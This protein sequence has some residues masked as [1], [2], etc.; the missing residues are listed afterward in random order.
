MSYNETVLRILRMVEHGA[1]TP[2][3]AAD[4]IDALYEVPPVS[5]TQPD[6]EVS[7]PQP[8]SESARGLFDQIVRTVEEAVRTTGQAVRGV[9]WRELGETI[10]SQTQRG[11]EEM[12]RALDE[13][14][15]GDWTLG[16]LGKQSHTFERQIPLPIQA[17]QTLTLELPA[18]DIYLTGGFDEG[19][20]GARISLRGADEAQLSALEQ[21][22]T[23]MVEH[24]E[25]GLKLR[26]PELENGITQEADLRLMV[27]RN[28]NVEV[29]L[30]GK[31]DVRIDKLDGKV[32]IVAQR[33]DIRLN[34]LRGSVTVQLANGDVSVLDMQGDTLS[35]N[36][37]HGDVQMRRVKVD[38]LQASLTHG[39][40]EAEA[41]EARHL[42]TETVNGDQQVQ[43]TQPVQGTV[44]LTTVK[45]DLLLLLPDGNDCTVSLQTLSGDIECGLELSQREQ[46]RNTVRGVAG[47]GTG[48]LVMETVHGDLSLQLTPHTD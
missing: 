35:L 27:P 21:T 6:P 5:E 9:N 47:Q 20:V 2:E 15:K 17:G 37:V 38:T 4:L 44:K 25:S 8:N 33:G 24:T 14:E 45:G 7:H 34:H 29:R 18:G 36:M 16:A 19:R 11:L 46:E 10:R 32:H 12:R 23:L 43:L 22:Y 40:L 1:L 13:L 3:E 41:L 48:T 42:T 28:V 31:G 26:L 30:Q 39:D